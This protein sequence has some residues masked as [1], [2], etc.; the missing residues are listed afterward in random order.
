[1]SNQVK[2]EFKDVA[3][4]GKLERVTDN[5]ENLQEL[6]GIR[7]QEYNPD[8]GDY[9]TRDL[10]VEKIDGKVFRIF[11]FTNMS[12]RKL[13]WSRSVSENKVDSDQK[14][15]SCAICG[16]NKVIADTYHIERL[17]K[18]VKEQ[19]EFSMKYHAD[20]IRC[21]DCKE[22]KFMEEKERMRL[23]GIQADKLRKKQQSALR[24]EQKNEPDH[25]EYCKKIKVKKQKYQP[26]D[27]KYEFLCGESI[28]NYA[29]SLESATRYHLVTNNCKACRI[30]NNESKAS[31]MNQD[32]VASLFVH[33][34]DNK[35]SGNGNLY[36]QDGVLI[37]YS[38]V[39]AIR[40]TEDD[41]SFTVISN[42]QCWSAGFAK[43]PN[44]KSKYNLP[45]TTLREITR[46]HDNNGNLLEFKIEMIEYGGWDNALVK[47]CDNYYL[48]GRDEGQGFITKLVR[49]ATS[50]KDAL[51]SMKPIE[52]IEAQKKK[53]KVIRQG[54]LFFVPT[55]EK[56]KEYDKQHFIKLEKT[57]NWE[58]ENKFE[59]L[60]FLLLNKYY[61]EL[62]SYQRKSRNYETDKLETETARIGD[63]TARTVINMIKF[64][65]KT[66][67]DKADYISQL[68]EVVELDPHKSKKLLDQHEKLTKWAWNKI[69][70]PKELKRC[71]ILNTN[72]F[73]QY[74]VKTM[75]KPDSSELDQTYVKGQIFHRNNDHRK[76]I[77]EQWY[78][79]FKN[80]VSQSWNVPRRGGGAGGD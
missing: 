20:S 66:S 73:S 3:I 51:E 70:V 22:R 40:Q 54:D 65:G 36:S 38:T 67:I 62:T 42:T 8:I 30:L 41:G 25:N 78:K 14:I 17:E 4:D 72:H 69:P 49:S 24:L 13:L 50:I 60:E 19:D 35:K 18:A 6:Y 28:G 74:Q 53:Q 79:V 37:H 48:V 27:Y 12:D 64:K 10:Y 63:S 56:F 7:V 23:E 77:L 43:C 26:E 57:M 11:D 1:M 45:L 44:F 9:E 58:Q 32:Q 39:E 80:V 55:K 34:I 68:N 5:T 76:L 71:Q 59:E 61:P 52:V 21:W 31:I 33:G 2:L 47:I 75:F 16:L 29:Y 15:V 46:D